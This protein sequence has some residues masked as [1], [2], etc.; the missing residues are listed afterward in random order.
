MQIKN[1]S[2]TSFKCRGSG[3]KTVS[4]VYSQNHSF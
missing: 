3:A 1:K 2:G 4:Q